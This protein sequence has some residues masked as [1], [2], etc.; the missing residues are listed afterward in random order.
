[1]KCS[2]TATIGKTL[3][4]FYNILSFSNVEISMEE[5]IE[6]MSQTL[7]ISNE[8][9]TNTPPPCFVSYHLYV[10]EEKDAVKESQTSDYEMQLY[11]DYMKREGGIKNWF[12]V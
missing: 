4:I 1:M 5:I 10:M 7:N 12:P 3:I 2:C 6:K 11:Q 9:V 8:N